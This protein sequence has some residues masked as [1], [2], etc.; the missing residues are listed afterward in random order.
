MAA[1]NAVKRIVATS[2]GSATSVTTSAATTTSGNLLVVMVF[3]F[4]NHIGASPVTDS[5]SNT[6][7]A[8]ISSTG[9]TQ[10]WAAMFYAANATGGASHTF[11][12]TASSSDYLT[13]VVFEVEGAAT[14]SVLSNTS[15]STASTASHSSGNIT[16]NTS[17]SEIFIGGLALSA[18]AEGTGTTSANYWSPTFLGTAATGTTEGAASGWRIVAPSTTSAFAV[19]TSTAANETI[20]VAGFKAESATPSSGG[21]YA[22]A[23]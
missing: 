18:A 20:I 5:K 8:A 16:A 15:S 23:G 10:G 19:T 7:T 2:S 14:S 22:F 1:L 21:A 13:M 11:T 6:W 12:F 3:C 17:V 9:T 4:G